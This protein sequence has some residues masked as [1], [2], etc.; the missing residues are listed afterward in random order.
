MLNTRV[1]QFSDT[2]PE[3]FSYC[4]RWGN[5]VQRGNGVQSATTGSARFCM[6]V[7][8][9]LSVF[10]GGCNHSK[11]QPSD[12]R[13]TAEAESDPRALM[14][15]AIQS[16]NWQLADR[17]ANAALI[18][19]PDDPDLV[20][21]VA[22]VNAFCDRKRDAAKLLIEAAKLADFQPASRVDFA[23]RA[24]VDVGEVYAAIELLELSL[25]RFPENN[26]Q[27]RML[28]GF[29]AEVQRNERLG[30][31]LKKLIQNRAFDLQLLLA[32]TDTA[33][34]R[35]SETTASR[36]MERCPED[37]RVRLVDAYL[38]LY[39][40]DAPGACTI[41]EDILKHH[42]DFAP[43]HAMYGHALALAER[44]DELPA[45]FETAPPQCPDFADYWFALGDAAMQNGKLAEAT[46]AFWEAT[47]RDPNRVYAWDRLRLVMHQLLASD[48]RY[49][50]AIGENELAVVT[51]QS[52]ALLA[53]GERFNE[54]AGGG[55]VSQTAAEKVARAL[56]VLGRVWEAEAWSAA[57]TTLT[58]DRSGQ[59]AGLRQEIIRALRT[60]PEWVDAKSASQK[61]DL[62]FLPEPKLEAGSNVAKRT[63]VIPSVSTHDHLRMVESADQWGLAG[64]GQGNNP[65]NARL[66]ALIRS[67]GVGGGAIDYDLDGLP[68]LLMMNSG[69]TMLKQDSA[70]NELMRNL[71]QVFVDVSERAGVI[72]RGFGQGVAVGDFNEDG[73]SDLFFANLG[74]NRLLRNNGDGTFTDCTERLNDKEVAWSTSAAFVDINSDSIA[75]LV[76]SNYCKTV[77]NL[78]K[79]C[80]DDAGV[81]GPCHPLKFPAEYDQFFSASNDGQFSDVTAQWVPELSPGRGLGIVSGLLDNNQLGTFVANDM[82][83]NFLYSRE[84]G[85]AM[86]LI[87]S[88][89]A[90]GVAVDGTTRS[91]A[92]MG[93]ASSDFDLD[94]DLDFYV[95]GFAREY[96]VLYEQISP[97]MWT[98]STAKLGLVDPTLSMVGFGTQAI[99][100]DNDG[101]D[102]IIVTNGHIG[103][104]NKP[105]VPPYELPLQ[106][107]RRGQDG[108]FAV[109]QDDDWGDYFRVGHVGRALWTTDVN[110]DGRNDVMIS[111]VDEQVRLLINE[112]KDQ[113]NR[114][115]FKLVAT[116][117]SRDAVGA[118]IRFKCN[119]QSRTMWLLS[120]DGYFCSNEK[121][122]IAGLAEADVVTDVV[123]T[124]QDGSIDR[125]GSIAANQV[126]LITQ[127][128]GE[129]FSLYEYSR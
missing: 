54:F 5:G 103:D 39:R 41:L 36:L 74:T 12:A 10:V 75:D 60:N 118:V 8:V 120:G 37:H 106:V 13:H 98:D 17:Y 69:G 95:T 112:T 42:P 66:A 40:H 80:P 19:Q 31:H 61:L 44:W 46:R 78:D 30:P 127:G 126:Y 115:G 93:I 114:V 58:Q 43:A 16:G 28:V 99:D 96:N 50:D 124:W 72:D 100:M 55:Q 51:D 11:D 116:Q 76:V 59:L 119:G 47:R 89:A 1:N 68:D 22:K 57:A 87:D 90:R 49:H 110:R 27:R 109:I 52:D 92:S 117:C 122:L 67:T 88:A 63:A 25:E 129:A 32:T 121:T 86:V 48:Q 91:Q 23:V 73:F 104:F 97:G 15:A 62:G 7:F 4:V 56:F 111:H 83:K 35:M 6:M 26:E 34:R 107:F 85:D 3:A 64:V 105:D 20:T 84:S 123:V 29:L 9:I 128:T 101:I 2:L 79:A 14:D 33:T 81:L 102:E 108:R 70:S 125:L 21:E 77:E 45:W 71:G 113:N 24:L 65:S 82:S 53:F 94:G 38:Y 18:A